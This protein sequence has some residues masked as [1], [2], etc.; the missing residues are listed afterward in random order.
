MRSVGNSA[1]VTL[2]WVSYGL[3]SKAAWTVKP[4]R[5]VVLTIRLTMAWWLTSG[6]PRQCFVMKLKRRCSMLFHLLV[7]GGKWQTGSFNSS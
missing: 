7:P 6:R 5:V 1:S 2:I 3:V 4:V